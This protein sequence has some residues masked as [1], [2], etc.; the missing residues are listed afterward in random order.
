[1]AFFLI[2]AVGQDP[3][4]LNTRCSILRSAGFVVRSAFGVAES[5]DLFQNTDFDLMLLCHSIPVEDRDRLIRIIRRTGSRI[6]IYVVVSA[7]KDFQVGLADGIVSSWPQDLIEQLGDVMEDTVR[8]AA[9][10]GCR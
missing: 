2:L 5:I 3:R 4:V 1:M 6:P 8:N 9:Q 7:T 10:A